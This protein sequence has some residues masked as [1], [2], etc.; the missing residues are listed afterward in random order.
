MIFKLIRWPLGKL[1]LLVDFV[2]RPRPPQRDPA[3]Q[4]SID[5]ATRGMALYQFQAC[6][7]CV[8]TR[9]AMRRLGV[10]IETRDASDDA[11]HRARLEQEG[12][13]IQVPCLYIPAAD[14]SAEWLYESNDII[15]R[16]GSLV[17]ATEG[18]A[19]ARTPA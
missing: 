1:V 5:E 18:A 14:G 19:A 4:A 2:T 3:L 16:L 6:P 7:F 17:S 10:E 8:K 13:R 11:T 12:G 9:R 15:A